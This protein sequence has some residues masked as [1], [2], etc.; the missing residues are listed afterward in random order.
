MNLFTNMNN[1]TFGTRNIDAEES[2]ILMEAISDRGSVTNA[3]PTREGDQNGRLF[4][5]YR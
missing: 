5:Y 4:S 3:N 2:G 1:V